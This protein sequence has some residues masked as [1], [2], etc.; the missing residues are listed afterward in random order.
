[1]RIP[2]H[3]LVRAI[4]VIFIVAATLVPAPADAQQQPLLTQ[5][6]ATIGTGNVLL[7]GE[8][9]Y[10][11]DT[12][13]PLAGLTGNL[14]QLPVFGINVGVGPIADLEI[15]GGPYDRLTI[16]G[17]GA[18][19][20]TADLSG[21][22]MSGSVTHDVEDISIGTRIT[23]VPEASVRPAVGF[24]FSVRLP[25]A[26]HPSGL[27]Q[28]TTDFSAS[29]LSG[30]SIGAV[31]VLGNLGFTIMSEPTNEPKQNDVLTYGAAASLK[32]ARH[33]ELV[34]EVNGRW[35]VRNGVAPIGTESRGRAQAGGAYTRGHIR[36][37]AAVFVGLTPIDPSIGV[38]AGLSVLFHAFTP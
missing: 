19:P 10:A 16:T 36:Y 15:S 22:V 20:F 1:V 3:F 24:L 23:I 13:Y 31:R 11:S 21:A 33:M 9:S 8:F 34:T 30:K 6:P 18:G 25:N 12:F 2:S 4:S 17:R 38:S 14:A 5:D 28:D 35:S 37:D 27:G 7:R 32:V 26:K 29:M